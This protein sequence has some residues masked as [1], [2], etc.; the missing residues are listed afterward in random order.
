MFLF[1]ILY[2]WTRIR[3]RRQRG[4]GERAGDEG[5]KYLGDLW[6]RRSRDRSVLFNFVFEARV[7]ISYYC[8]AA[9]AQIALQSLLTHLHLLCTYL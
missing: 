2:S 1:N 4:C 7:T 8:G 9:H 5:H 3:L 6:S